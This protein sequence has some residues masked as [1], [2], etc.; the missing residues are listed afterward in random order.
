LREIDRKLERLTEAYLA[1]TLTLDEF[2]LAKSNLVREKQDLKDKTAA[3]EASGGNWFEPAIR[4]LKEAQNNGFMADMEG[5]E[6][7]KLAQ[8]KK[9]GSNFTIWDR[10]LSVVARR[11]W[12]NR[13]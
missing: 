11:A 7:G 9:V 1:E 6:A 3:V 2:R 8:L 5:N 10:H 4:F 12:P 13:I